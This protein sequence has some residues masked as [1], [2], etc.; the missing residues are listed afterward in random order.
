MESEYRSVIA[1]CSWCDEVHFLCSPTD[2]ICSIRK[3]TPK[4]H[5]IVYIREE[6][7]MHL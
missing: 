6:F 1:F 3:W 7:G 5:G 2:I 4:G